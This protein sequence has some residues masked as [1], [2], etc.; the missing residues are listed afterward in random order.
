M[1]VEQ[2]R[3]AVGIFDHETRRT[4]RFFVR[5]RL[6]CYP[7]CFELPLEITNIRERIELLSVIVPSRIEG[8]NVLFEHSLEQTDHVIAVF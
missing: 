2:N 3:I 6:E 5:F 7:F 8:K 4:G 1:L